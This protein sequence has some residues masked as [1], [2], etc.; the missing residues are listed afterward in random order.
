[1]A[2]GGAR[3]PPSRTALRGARVNQAGL[4][5]T[6][7]AFAGRRRNKRERQRKGPGDVDQINGGMAVTSE[8]RCRGAM[9]G[10]VGWRHGTPVWGMEGLV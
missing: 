1:M 10:G 3:L 6:P 5:S 8:V 2:T 4:G 7:K 9:C